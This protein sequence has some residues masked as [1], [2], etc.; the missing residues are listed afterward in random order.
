MK[1]QPASFLILLMLG[2]SI[3]FGVL[4]FFTEVGISA[5]LGISGLLIIVCLLDRFLSRK[6]FAQYDIRF[7]SPSRLHV[8]QEGKVL[9]TLT[10]PR[11]ASSIKIGI[12]FPVEVGG[13]KIIREFIL[14]QTIDQSLIAWELTPQMRG[15]YEIK[16][17]RM[18]FPSALKL[19]TIRKSFAVQLILEVYANLQFDKRAMS[20]LLLNRGHLGTKLQRL[21][22]QGREFDQLRSYYDGDSMDTIHWKASAKRNEWMT[23][24]FQVE[25]T[26]EVYA[27]IDAS[28]LSRKVFPDP[29]YPRRSQ[30]LLERYIQSA[31]YLGMIASNNK[32]KFG[33]L[34]YHRQVD[35]F[36]KAGTGKQHIG[37]CQKKFLELTATKT[38]PDY[39]GIFATIT[40][41]LRRRALLILLM[42]LSDPI[43]GEACKKA[44]PILTRRHLVH[45]TAVT[46]P[47][48][49]K[50]FSS[51]ID[52][53]DSYALH[54]ALGNHLQWKGQFALQ[55]EFRQLGASLEFLPTENITLGI[56]NHYISVKSKQ[57]L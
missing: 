35:T 24:T 30:M 38:L 15:T 6:S 49:E 44:L 2:A 32:D 37:L 28:Q 42:D 33:F 40:T 36:M 48:V 5:M 9:A 53:N 25:R 56:V 3:V 21:R 17:L 27:V 41:T 51:E 26:Q 19:G 16:H 12:P 8:H 54:R 31:S 50:V 52:E 7:T 43:A 18:E 10:H 14:D 4:S 20:S 29:L 1:W 34:S 22:G 57:L 11:G 39:E 23:K 46:D 55:K 47:A 13:Q 45:V